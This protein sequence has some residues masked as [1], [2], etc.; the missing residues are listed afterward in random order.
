MSYGY[1]TVPLNTNLPYQ[2]IPLNAPSQFVFTLH[3]GVTCVGKWF[4]LESISSTNVIITSDVSI[5]ANVP[6]TQMDTIQKGWPEFKEEDLWEPC[7]D[8]PASMS[9]TAGKLFRYTSTDFFKPYRRVR[10]TVT[11]SMPADEKAQRLEYAAFRLELSI[12]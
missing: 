10:F 5:I 1:F 6:W 12:I 9:V 2:K 3:A 4:Q 11:P 7:P 8:L